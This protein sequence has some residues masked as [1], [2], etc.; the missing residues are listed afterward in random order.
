[1]GSRSVVFI[2][3]S[4]DRG[5]AH[6]LFGSGPT[7][8]L[9]PILSLSPYPT[10]GEP[11]GQSKRSCS[12]VCCRGRSR[13]RRKKRRAGSALRRMPPAAAIIDDT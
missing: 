3:P 5:A 10:T 7:N 4:L 2:V 12:A 11:F 1:V 9:A 6:G 8:F 13:S